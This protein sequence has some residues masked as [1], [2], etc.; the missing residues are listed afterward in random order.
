MT[1]LLITGA[2]VALL[3]ERAQARI[4]QIEEIGR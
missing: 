4:D 1:A 3:I 2:L